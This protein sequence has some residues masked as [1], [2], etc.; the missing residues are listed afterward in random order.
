MYIVNNVQLNILLLLISLYS[1]LNSLDFHNLNLAVNFR[2]CNCFYWNYVLYNNHTIYFLFF[3]DN[4]P[5]SG[6][7]SKIFS[8]VVSND[9]NRDKRVNK[10]KQTSVKLR[11]SDWSKKTDPLHRKNLN[12]N[13]KRQIFEDS[14]IKRHSMTSFGHFG[15]SEG[16]ENCKLTGFKLNVAKFP[17]NFNKQNKSVKPT[18]RLGEVS[19]SETIVLHTD[20]KNSG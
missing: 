12:Q 14:K 16:P 13:D 6:M 1:M 11:V 10:K 19:K 7:F 15:L 20:F 5:K 4:R 18:R 3:L 17:N 2:I 9:Q 8:S